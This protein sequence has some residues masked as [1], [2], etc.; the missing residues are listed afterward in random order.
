MTD[1]TAETFPTWPLQRMALAGMAALMLAAC[2][3][4][5]KT[6]DV[7]GEAAPLVNRDTGGK[8]LSVAVRIYQLKDAAEFSKLTF[9][10]VAGGRPESELLGQ[11][12]LSQ[13]EIIMVPSG[14]QTLSDKLLDSTKY[15]GIVG[16]FRQP[17]ANFWR[18]LIDAEKIRDGGLAFKVQDCYLVVL[19]PK[20]VPIPG[21]PANAAPA[22]HETERMSSATSARGNRKQ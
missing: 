12:L 10:T 21:Q 2:A 3:T 9:D 20:P 17:D 18:F 14:K 5:P 4:G 1:R 8:S 11:D 22:C 6:Y 13:N 7:K 19:N 15:I 16:L